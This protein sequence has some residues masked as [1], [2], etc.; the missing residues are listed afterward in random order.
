M[1]LPVDT[2]A[3]LKKCL[4]C[5][6]SKNG[7]CESMPIEITDNRYELSE[8]IVQEAVKELVDIPQTIFDAI[9]DLVPKKHRSHLI[10]ILEG[11]EPDIVSDIAG[12][13]IG[14]IE[15]RL[16]VK[17]SLSDTEFCCKNWR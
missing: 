2:N 6:N 17:V 11:C 8:G 16:E 1:R 15:N 5:S 4:F 3:G 7:V 10:E 9:E 14:V 13:I 12:V